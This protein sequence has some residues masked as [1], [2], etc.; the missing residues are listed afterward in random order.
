M[1]A[2]HASEYGNCAYALSSRSLLIMTPVLL[3]IFVFAPQ[4]LQ[5]WLGAD[6]AARSSGVLRIFCAGTSKFHCLRAFCSF[7]G[8]GAAGRYRETAFAGAA[9][10]RCGL[11]DPFAADGTGR[12]CPSLELPAFPGC[13]LFVCSCVL[14]RDASCPLH[15][16]STSIRKACLLLC[17]LGAALLLPFLAGGSLSI[18][19]V[20]A[21][22]VLLA[23]GIAVWKYA[24][25]ANKRNL[26]LNHLTT[27]SRRHG[28]S[29]VTL[30]RDEVTIQQDKYVSEPTGVAVPHQAFLTRVRAATN[31]NF[32]RLGKVSRHLVRGCRAGG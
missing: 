12:C 26:F 11:G 31:T 23:F 2:A 19:L 5:L 24:F 14:A 32:R 22:A 13:A 20:F 21:A 30:S 4:L 28:E 15:S 17:G 8:P 7:A 18:Q 3:V 16:R 29:E 9:L 25:D 6:F 1:L 10:L 27:D